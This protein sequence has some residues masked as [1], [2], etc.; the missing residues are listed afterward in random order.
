[1][2]A[3]D[4]PNQIQLSSAKAS[5]FQSVLPRVLGEMQKVQRSWSLLL[6]VLQQDGP[7]GPF[8]DE[9]DA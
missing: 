9:T 7:A 8:S 2:L 6:A 1:V 3:I 5:D 4:K